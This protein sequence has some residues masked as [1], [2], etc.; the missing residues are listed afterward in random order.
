MKVFIFEATNSGTKEL[1]GKI[2]EINKKGNEWY[3]EDEWYIKNDT[4]IKPKLV[5]DI[6]NNYINFKNRKEVADYYNLPL[7]AIII[8]SQTYNLKR[9]KK[10]KEKKVKP[11][12]KAKPVKVKKPSKFELLDKD[13]FKCDY[14]KLSNKELI[15]KYNVSETTIWLWA[16]KIGVKRPESYY[17]NIN[18][19]NTKKTI[20][21]K[22]M[23]NIIKEYLKGNI[24]KWELSSL[25]KVGFSAVK[26]RIAE[27]GYKKPIKNSKI[28]VKLTKK[29]DTLIK[30]LELL[31]L[32]YLRCTK[33]KKVK[34]VGY[35]HK[36]NTK[37]GYHANCK[38]CKK[39]KAWGSSST[40]P[41][42]LQFMKDYFEHRC[43]Y[44]GA[45][46]TPEN[47]TL[48]H[49]IARSKGGNSEINNIVLACFDCNTKKYTTD[50]CD[51]YKY[52]RIAKERYDKI[53]YYTKIKF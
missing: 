27:K 29:H 53:V 26:S 25:L 48:D 4:F 35:F 50:L 6:K 23:D 44:C 47:Y 28:K 9:P 16:K 33:C 39:I 40:T 20:W 34:K 15:K 8:I 5:E 49:V 7:R 42:Q 36:D 17:L 19:K 21:T 24:K 37:T 31:K 45:D 3:Y 18:V 22:E 30:N 43:A 13:I 10:V 1:V 38:D 52:D 32:G 41:D 2:V 46:I 51:L 11:I 14:S 12:K